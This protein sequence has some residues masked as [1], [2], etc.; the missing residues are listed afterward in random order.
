MLWVIK[1]KTQIMNENILFSK[2]ANNFADHKLLNKTIFLDYITFMSNFI[3]FKRTMILG[4]CQKMCK[5]VIFLQEGTSWFCTWKQMIAWNHMYSPFHV[6][7]NMYSPFDVPSNMY[8]PFDVPSYMYSPFDAP[9]NMYSPFDAPS[10]MY[11]PFDVPSNMYSPFDAPSNM[12]SPFDAP[13]N[14]KLFS[15]YPLDINILQHIADL[16]S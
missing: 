9:S 1:H 3:N 12:Y 6:P 4:I 11:S 10:N 13:S 14:A 2:V 7:S 5:N 15:L 16:W 8:S